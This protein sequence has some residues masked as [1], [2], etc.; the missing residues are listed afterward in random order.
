MSKSIKYTVA[1]VIRNKDNPE[2]V[3]IV[4]RP[5]GDPDLQEHWGFPAGSLKPG[6]L[7]EDVVTRVCKERLNCEV[8]ITRFL[9]MM[10]QKRN[11]YDIFLM[12]MEAEVVGSKQPNVKEAN[13]E[14]T[15]YVDQKWTSDF[16]DLEASAK[17]G[18][19]CS[20]IFLT[21]Q[22]LLDRDEWLA[23]LEG[24]DKVG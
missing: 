23:S 12:D 21:D 13:T 7:F 5:T 24:S 22:G 9:G 8:K 4:K 6:E 20:S 14:D 1:V 18:S 2:E 3:L 10:F 17:A 11:S 16:T 19:C 15:A